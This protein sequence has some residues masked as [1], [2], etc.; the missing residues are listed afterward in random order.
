MKPILKWA[1]GKRQLLQQIISKINTLN[2]EYGTY[3][4][5]FIG[6]GAVFFELE[7]RRAI[8]NDYNWELVNLY[9][10]I[11]DN[12]QKII[13]FLFQL[14]KESDERKFYEIRAIDRKNNWPLDNKSY[15][16][17]RTIYLNKNCFNGLYRVNKAGQFNVPY[18]KN[19]FSSESINVENICSI[20]DFLNTNNITIKQGDFEEACKYARRGSLVYFDPP[21]DIVSETSKF[22]EYTNIGFGI[23]EQERLKKLVDKL[24]RR[25]VYVILSNSKTDYIC[26]LYNEYEPFT[27]IISANRIINS[28]IKLRGKVNEVL[29]DNFFIVNNFLNREH[30]ENNE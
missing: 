21:Y 3:Y 4:E 8:I 26:N 14:Q 22:T 18:G 20:S 19:R 23:K 6:G 30:I 13:D 16:A 10:E 27:E 25:G 24:T 15:M 12:P 28:N 5:P 29:I 7:P 17:A 2:G 9:K 1:G 11:K